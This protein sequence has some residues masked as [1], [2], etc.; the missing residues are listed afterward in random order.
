ME[1]NVDFFWL[2][3]GCHLTN[4]LRRLANDND[5]MLMSESITASCVVDVYA[6][7]LARS[8]VHESPG[9]RVWLPSPP[10]DVCTSISIE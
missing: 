10:D 3:P 7:R 2:L 9:R 1:N 4:E 8:S 5:C 6:H